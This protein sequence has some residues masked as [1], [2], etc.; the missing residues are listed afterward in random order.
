[1]DFTTA[2]EHYRRQAGDQYIEPSIKR[3]TR[4][5]TMWKL[6]DRHGN[7]IALVSADGQILTSGTALTTPEDKTNVS[8]RNNCFKDRPVGTTKDAGLRRLRKDR[9]AKRV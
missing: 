8:N 5:G 3:S 1:M 7:V 2:K 9:A 6:K 4:I